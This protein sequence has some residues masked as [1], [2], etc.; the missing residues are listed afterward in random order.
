MEAP[1]EISSKIAAASLLTRRLEGKVAVVTGGAAGIGESIVRLF[2][3]HGARI[4]IMDLQEDL[5]RRICH[6]L[7]GAS[8][9]VFALGDVTQEDDVARAVDLAVQAFGQLDIMVNNA[10]ISGEA[11]H[12][13]RHVSFSEFKR[14]VDVNLCGVFL[15]T[16]HAA[17]EMVPRRRGSIV[18]LGSVASV[19]GG[20]GPHAY[21]ASKHGI[22]GMVKSAAA[23]LG[24][25]GIRVNCVSPY[26][27]ATSLCV[28]HYPADER[29]DMAAA[30]PVPASD[31][32]RFLESQGNLRGVTL[33]ADDVAA[34]VLF[35]A[36][37]EARY[38]SGHNL[39]VDGGFT[40]VN[41][42]LKVF[43]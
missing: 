4:C 37:D 13:I 20:V 29:G 17:R 42:A 28:G 25:Y 26:G 23:E 3:A 12:D 41:H 10:G 2:H 6:S 11:C 18:A 9:A 21:A 38:V 8:A 40:S 19:A 15:G 34:A 43:R 31:V 16:K 5:G 39:L 36:S 30:A 27:V 7:G 1:S 35:L 22:V 33:T 14:V 24:K 32:T